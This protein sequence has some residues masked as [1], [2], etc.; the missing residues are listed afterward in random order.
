MAHGPASHIKFARS[1]PL[2]PIAYWCDHMFGGQGY[3][4]N[5]TILPL[6]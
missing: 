2:A 5:R 3:S 4:P 6:T 1:L